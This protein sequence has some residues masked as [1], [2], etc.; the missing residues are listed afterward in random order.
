MALKSF[1]RPAAVLGALSLLVG[2]VAPAA[3]P[4]PS[5]ATAS[6]APTT[7]PPA[8]ARPAP[9][10]LA[11]SK[12]KHIVVIMQENRTFDHYFGT[13]PGGDGIPMQGGV[14]TVCAPDPETKVCVKPYHDPK[15]V[16]AGGPHGA[17]AA[18]ADINGGKMDGFI[19]QFLS[20]IHI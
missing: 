14:P 7:N 15:D 12:L 10:A 8:T 5:A 11:R 6:P 4:S 13:Y 19:E 9:L 17:G 18:T 2:C 3:A 20:L 1:A 16:N